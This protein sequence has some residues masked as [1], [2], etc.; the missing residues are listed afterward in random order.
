MSSGARS[1]TLCSQGEIPDELGELLMQPGGEQ[2]IE[3]LHRKVRER[4]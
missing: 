4:H 3:K 1:V 2:I